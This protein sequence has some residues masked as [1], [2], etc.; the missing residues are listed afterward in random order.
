MYPDCKL[1]RVVRRSLCLVEERRKEYRIPVTCRD[2]RVLISNQTIYLLQET[3]QEAGRGPSI[4]TCDQT[5]LGMSE[6]FVPRMPSTL[7]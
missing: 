2:C 6:I 3:S 4:D 1:T 7:N 5:A